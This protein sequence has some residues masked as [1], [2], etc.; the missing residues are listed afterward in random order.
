MKDVKFCI[1]IWFQ[2]NLLRTFRFND[3][4]TRSKVINDISTSNIVTV[5]ENEDLGDIETQH[6]F[7]IFTNKI[8]YFEIYE[9]MED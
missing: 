5:T 3:R 4:Y 1:D 9:E 7:Y 8:C 6:T 2:G